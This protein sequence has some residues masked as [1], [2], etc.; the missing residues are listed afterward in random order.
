MDTAKRRVGLWMN[1]RTFFAPIIMS[2]IMLNASYFS[3][4]PRSYPHS[5]WKTGK[6]TQTKIRRSDE[7]HQLSV[8]ITPQLKI[9][10]VCELE[11]SL[12]WW[13]CVC[14]GEGDLHFSPFLPVHFRLCSLCL[15]FW[16]PRHFPALQ[17]GTKHFRPH[18]HS[19]R[20]WDEHTVKLKTQKAPSAKFF[21]P[22]AGNFS[23][24][25]SSLLHR[26]FSVAKIQKLCAANIFI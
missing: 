12:R 8:L 23:V 6:K 20:G 3:G 5:W 15:A 21:V 19:H 24:Q 25:F 10:H 22:H 11:V 4:L 1:E 18:I 13:K 2:T 17:I 26:H 9:F 14:D 16:Q 7:D